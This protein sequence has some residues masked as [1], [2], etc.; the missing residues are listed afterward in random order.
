M[1]AVPPPTV[2]G[3]LAQAWPGLSRPDPS[4][5]LPDPAPGEERAG[6]ER[7]GAEQSPAEWTPGPCIC[8]RLQLSPHEAL[9][10]S[11]ARR[12]KGPGLH[13]GPALQVSAL[14][15]HLQPSQGIKPKRSE[16]AA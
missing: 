6:H 3:M 1:A 9:C 13:S 10:L 11:S 12:R 14:C 15:L 16:E 8:S 5:G 2:F 7:R 4:R